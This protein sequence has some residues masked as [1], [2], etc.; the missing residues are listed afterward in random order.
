MKPFLAIGLGNPL[1]GDD[2]IGV[3]VA[4]LL[5]AD[6]ALADRLDAVCGGTDL[7]R[8]MDLMPGRDCVILIDAAEGGEPGK[9]AVLDELP[10]DSGPESAH[11]LSPVR[12]LQLLRT[13]SPALDAVRFTWVLVHIGAAELRPALSPE[14][15]TAVLDAADAVRRLAA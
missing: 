11:A 7:I 12:C 15:E 5:A 10:P 3:R 13:I 6:G 8:Y 2:G 9:L 4:R 1:M 14:V